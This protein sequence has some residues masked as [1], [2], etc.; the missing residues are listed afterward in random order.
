MLG[1]LFVIMAPLAGWVS[2]V[3]LREWKHAEEEITQFYLADVADRYRLEFER[4][5]AYKSLQNADS[6]NENG[7]RMRL[8]RVCFSIATLMLLWKPWVAMV[9]CVSWSM[10]STS[11]MLK[12]ERDARYDLAVCE[13]I[14]TCNRAFSDSTHLLK[15]NFMSL[16]SQKHSDCGFDA[17]TGFY[18]SNPQ[19]REIFVRLKATLNTS[20]SIGVV[21]TRTAA[22]VFHTFGA[23]EQLAIVVVAALLLKTLI[24]RYLLF[25]SNVKIAKIRRPYLHCDCDECRCRNKQDRIP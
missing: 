14:Y 13:F 6:I 12:L 4:C 8:L 1:F 23:F 21:F 9:F 16:L 19:C 3:Y 18:Y 17:E 10:W 11:E 15:C 25:L 24:C 22:D 5:R 2:Y 20:A 7:R